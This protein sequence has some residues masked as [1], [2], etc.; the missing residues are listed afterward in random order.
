MS[1]FSVPPIGRTVL[2][3]A[4]F[5]VFALGADDDAIFPTGEPVVGPAAGVA[6]LWL[7]SSSPSMLAGRRAALARQRRREPGVGQGRMV[8]AG[9]AGDGFPAVLVV[10]GL[11]RWC[12]EIWGGGG[13]YAMRT[14]AELGHFL[15]LVVV[16]TV[17]CTAL[18]TALGVLLIAG[19]TCGA[20]R[21][22][23]AGAPRP[24]W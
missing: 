17:L 13:R 11:R 4:T 5:V 18:R 24:P 23:G 22:L 16:S 21:P 2:W 10:L 3:L 12:P 8:P 1:R 19:E 6:L 14:M 20:V 15:A 9:R 7:A